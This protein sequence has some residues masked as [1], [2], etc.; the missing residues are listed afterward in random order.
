MRRIQIGTLFGSVLVLLVFNSFAFAQNEAS[1]TEFQW[2]GGTGSQSWQSDANWDL[3]DFPNDTDPLDMD[4]PTA[5][6]SV[7]LGANLNVSIGTSPVTVAGLT[8]GGT[9]GVVTSEI[10]SG[11]P[12][13]I[14]H[15]KN[16]F[17][18]EGLLTEKDADFNNDGLVAGS[19]FLI[20]QRNYLFQNTGPDNINDQGDANDDDSVNGADLAI[21]Q[22]QYGLGNS[23]FTQGDAFLRSAGA[24]G[25]VNRITAPI[26]LEDEPLEIDAI[27]PLVI[28]VGANI[29]NS[30]PDLTSSSRI[31]VLRGTVTV[32]SEIVVT[33]VDTTP[34]SGGTDLTLRATASRADGNGATLILNGIVR[35]ANPAQTGSVTFGGGD[36]R[37]EIYGDN[38]LGGTVR[39]G[40][41]EIVLGHD[42]ALGVSS[43]APFTP[44]HVRPGGTFISDN[45]NRNIPNKFTLQSNFNFAGDKTLTLSGE[46][47]QTNNRGFNNNIEAPGELI[48]DGLLNIWEDDEALLREFD[49]FGTGTT[50]ITGLIRDDFLFS[51]QDRRINQSGPGVLIIDVGLGDNNHS[52]PTTISRGNFHYAN[53]DSLNVGGGLIVSSGGAIGVD[54]GVATNSTFLQKIDPTSTGGLML[55]ASD[56]SANLDFT[57]FPLSNA[58]NMTVA[59]PETGLTYT[60]IITPANSTYGLG[61]GSGTLTLPNAQLSGANALE[62]RNE[63]TVE[64]LGDNTYSGTTSIVLRS[65]S[66]DP[67]TLVVDKLTNGG[68]ASSIGS[69]SSDASNLYIQGATL[70]Y[71]GTGD[72]TDRLFTIGTKG[73]TI[74]SSGTGAVVFSNTGL[75]GRDDA[76]SRLGTLDDFSGRPDEIVEI[77]DTSDIVVGMA[78]S[79]PDGGGT[80]TQA[81]CEPSGANCIPVDTVVTSVGTHSVV[82][83]NSF[84]FILKENTTIVFGTVERTLTLAG[85][86]ANDN[87]LASVISD[88]GLGGVVSVDKVDAGK[89]IL[90][91]A[92]TYTG[93]TTVTEGILSI[94]NGY[95]ADTSTVNLNSSGMLD[96][97]F[98]GADVIDSLVLDG[99]ALSD[100]IYGATDG[101][102]GYNVLAALSGSGFLNV[103]NVP[104]PL[105]GALAVVPEPSA[106]LLV[107]IA[108]LGL[109]GT[110]KQV[111]RS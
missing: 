9:S 62:V 44:A 52:G 30:A 75:L 58:G 27:N 40:G 3:P 12:A 65:G 37:I 76:E 110:R 46:I 16:Y 35:D 18:P 109:A 28:D 88:S 39:T 1:F 67:P 29:T 33:D 64:L 83:N 5:D 94:T 82:I 7:G 103:G 69:S 111:R 36:G 49:F 48:L 55:A 104:F 24:A 84:P 10:S 96:L 53:N 72:S 23:F 107:S 73:L 50:R 86:N 77:D 68:V 31:S 100:G 70:K 91:G 51:G 6:L 106:L 57:S 19:D 20:W 85:T 108:C 25:A 2:I 97:D 32:N 71:V 45:D 59:A 21:W 56:A 38:D 13:G 66:G 87:T 89:W 74:D 95:L 22:E 78:V 98:T 61:G 105:V 63:G 80:F 17:E 4:Y 15:F 11:G 42:H 79:D 26:H 41:A 47:T 102:M 60:G 54:T 90:S 34:M 93:S 8:M 81:P 92:N 43:L 99:V 101:G 14:L